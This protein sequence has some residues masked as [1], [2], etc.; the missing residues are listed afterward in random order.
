[1]KRSHLDEGGTAKAAHLH[2]RILATSDLHM[3]LYPHDYF[4]DRPDDAR[5]L[6]ALAP[7]IAAARDEAPNCLLLDNGD[8]IQGNPM[9]DHAAMAAAVQPR[10]RHPAIAAMNVLG[11]DAATVGNHE[12]NYGLGFLART[13]A[14]AEFPVVLANLYHAPSQGGDTIF[15]PFAVIERTA[16]DSHGDEVTLRIGITG[17]APTET[18]VWD[19]ERLRDRVTAESI[20]QSAARVLTAMHREGCDL[21]VALCHAGLEAA[22]LAKE[23][24]GA[25]RSLA[26]A[27]GFDVV[28]AGHTH[29]P[30][31][32]EDSDEGRIGDTVVVAPGSHGRDLGQVDLVLARPAPDAGWRPARGASTRR[33]AG[34]PPVGRGT[35]GQAE[36]ARVLNSIFGDHQD[37]L[38]QVRRPIGRISAPVTSHFALA[39]DYSAPGVIAWGLRRHLE[40]A[41]DPG[42]LAAAPLLVST[43]AY[44]AGG[45]A[46]PDGYVDIPPGDLL[47]RHVNEIYPF[48]NRVLVY[49]VRTPLLRAWLERAASVF[50]QVEPDRRGAALLTHD[51]PSYD[52][53]MIDGL[54]WQIDLSRPAAFDTLGRPVPG[55]GG[56]VRGLSHRGGPLDPDAEFHFAVGSFRAAGSGGFPSGWGRAPVLAPEATVPQ[57][58][59]ASIA[60][61]GALR[62]ERRAPWH[63][64]PIEGASVLY[65]S[66][67]GALRHTCRMEELGLSPTATETMRGFTLFRRD[68]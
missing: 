27:G 39:G 37:T 17:F 33:P 62:V 57:I 7:A 29:R 64:S 35:P 5:G 13:Y 58:L 45:R 32:Q 59:A 9:G 68:L 4:T 22:E 41:L 14:Q 8:L 15:P 50:R 18:T 31:P 67:P 46:G 12:F 56:R 19:R 10:R 55:G 6:A 66:G 65:P 11:Y 38:A 34:P 51:V 49:R 47:M 40:T 3:Q 48:P 23:S 21:T 53:D 28:V 42:A 26:A 54:E 60:E 52:F 25:A 30:F 63:F 1:M 2:L 36:Y 44:A 61:V 16:T 24:H 20:P 43:A